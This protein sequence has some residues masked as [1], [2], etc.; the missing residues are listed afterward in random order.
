MNLL[1]IKDDLSGGG[2]VHTADHIEHGGLTGTIGP[3]QAKDRALGN[4]EIDSADR[5]KPPKADG[6]ILNLQHC[7]LVS[8]ILHVAGPP[9]SVL[10]EQ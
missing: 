4:L 7:C 10:C 6:K 8:V 3:D 1:A 2:L 5:H 9:F